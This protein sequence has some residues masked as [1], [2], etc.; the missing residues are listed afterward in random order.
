MGKHALLGA[1]ILLMAEEMIM[2][3]AVFNVRWNFDQ[4]TKVSRIWD[5]KPVENLTQ[6][7]NLT[8]IYV[9]CKRQQ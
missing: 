7:L 5:F 4:V 3:A 9:Q 2:Y 1:S 6:Y 8:F